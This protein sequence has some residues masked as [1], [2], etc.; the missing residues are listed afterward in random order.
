MTAAERPP[1]QLLPLRLAFAALIPL[2]V[3]G[4]C[5]ERFLRPR[6]ERLE[7]RVSHQELGRRFAPTG[8][9]MEGAKTLTQP[10]G[11]EFLLVE[12]GVPE[13]RISG[14]RAQL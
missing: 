9:A 12:D 14:S 3:S 1:L 6:M 2:S 10:V 8:Q 7:V 13:R 4:C 11:A 5:E